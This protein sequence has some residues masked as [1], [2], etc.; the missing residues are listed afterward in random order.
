MFDIIRDGISF[1]FGYIYTASLDGINDAFKDA[2]AWK[3]A[4]WSS[5]IASIE[6]AAKEKLNTLVEAIRN[7][8]E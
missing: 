7:N 8:A 5:K 2:I 3:N 1:D 4:S 6:V